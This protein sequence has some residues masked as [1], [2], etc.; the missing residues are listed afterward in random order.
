LLPNRTAT[1]ID[2][3]PAAT[4]IRLAATASRRGGDIT[5]V[6]AKT[7]QEKQRSHMLVVS[8]RPD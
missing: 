2:D 4:I 5:W 1:A 3:R 8:L 6:K 7:S